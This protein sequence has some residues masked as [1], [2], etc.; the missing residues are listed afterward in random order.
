M[1]MPEK[2]DGLRKESEEV[3]T[4]WVFVVVEKVTYCLRLKDE[5][6]DRNWE[7]R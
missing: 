1:P 2:S 4:K 6:R 5:R 3:M 7:V